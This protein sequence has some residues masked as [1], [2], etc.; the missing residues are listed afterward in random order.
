MN[1]N[2]TYRTVMVVSSLVVSAPL[3]HAQNQETEPASSSQL[4]GIALPKG[5][6]RV[7]PKSVPA[8]VQKLLGSLVQAGGSEVKQGRNEVLAWTGAG[9]KK[10]NA[11]QMLKQLEAT[12]KQ[13]GWEYSSDGSNPQFTLVSLLKTQ[14]TRRAVI[15]VWIPGD[16]ATVLA[17]TEMLR[18]T[19]QTPTTPQ[20]EEPTQDTP[21]VETP[22]AEEDP[23]ADVTPVSNTPAGATVLEVNGSTVHL[24]VMKGANPKIPAFPTLAPKAGYVRGF[25]KDI[26]GKP[27]VGARIGVRSTAVGGGYSGAQGKTDAKG[28]YEIMVPFGAAHFYNAGYAVDYGEGRVALGLHP[29]DGELDSFASNVGG[30]ENFVLMPYGIA[31]RDGVQENPRYSGN[32][33]GGCVVLSWNIADDNPIWQQPTDIP[34]NSVIEFTLTPQTPLLD[35]SK[36]RTFVIRKT[37]ANAGSQLYIVNIPLAMYKV[38]AK[39]VGGGALKMKEVGPNGGSAFGI[40][41]KEATGTADL[42]LRPSTPKADM[43]TASRGNWEH[44]SISLKR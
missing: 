42:Q 21:V 18:A 7:K 20:Q 43:V 44:I 16:E 35:G 11:A 29:A 1:L 10:A 25:V 3:A 24:N 6:Q 8:D 37:V 23:V 40:E 12:S 33:Y 4:A 32:Y 2:H 34:Q 41:P 28:Y 5:A 17:W 38:S 26:K 19:P 15:G 31:D 14:P 30:V 36:G 27:L 9:Y 22:I 13:G 39:L